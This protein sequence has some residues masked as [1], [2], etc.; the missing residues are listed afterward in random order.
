MPI[1]MS[2]TIEKN[3]TFMGYNHYSFQLVTKLA[4]FFGMG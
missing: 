2:F 4:T 1:F 3:Q